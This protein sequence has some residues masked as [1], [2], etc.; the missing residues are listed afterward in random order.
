MSHHVLAC[1]MKRMISLLGVQAADEGHRSLTAA[2]VCSLR[3]CSL[4]QQASDTFHLKTRFPNAS[5]DARPSIHGSGD[6]RAA[7]DLDGVRDAS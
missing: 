2:R 7:A 4:L 1:N 6:A 3:V 5:V